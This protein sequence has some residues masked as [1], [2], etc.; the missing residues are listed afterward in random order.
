MRTLVALSLA[1]FLWPS[2]SHALDEKKLVDMTYPFS[3]A[4]Q[5]WPTAKPFHLEKISEGRTPAGFRSPSYEYSGSALERLPLLIFIGKA[6]IV[7]PRGAPLRICAP[8][9]PRPG[10][11]FAVLLHLAAVFAF[12]P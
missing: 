8:A 3:E 6:K 7:A 12:N 2:Q 9:L 4:A 10:I 1:L 11:M 5:H